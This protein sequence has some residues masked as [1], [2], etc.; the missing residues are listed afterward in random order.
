M[1]EVSMNKMGVE[2]CIS[3]MSDKE[4]CVIVGRCADH[5]L[6]DRED[7][8]PVFIHADMEKGARRIVELHG[9]TDKKP[10]KRLAIRTNEES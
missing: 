7:A 9:E 5:I 6:K 10:V 8:L 1:E 2:L 4:P 3:C